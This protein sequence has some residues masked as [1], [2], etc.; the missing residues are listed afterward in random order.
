MSKPPS[1][2][3][4]TLRPRDCCGVNNSIL[5]ERVPKKS[6]RIKFLSDTRT[7][8]FYYAVQ[9]D[10]PQ[11]CRWRGSL[12]ESL[13]RSTKAPLLRRMLI[14]SRFTRFLIISNLPPTLPIRRSFFMSFSILQR[15][16]RW[17][18]VQLK[19]EIFLGDRTKS[20]S[21]TITFKNDTPPTTFDKKKRQKNPGDCLL[22]S[23]RLEETSCCCW[24]AFS[25]VISHYAS[26]VTIVNQLCK[27]LVQQGREQ[28]V[29]NVAERH[30]NLNILAPSGCWALSGDA[31]W[32]RDI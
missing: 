27:R 3:G 24:G 18:E 11:H 28:V 14:A 15:P 12:Y 1:C 32:L 7:P 25:C 20:I 13:A 19:Y 26:A 5:L 21:H 2:T 8:G 4:S 9:A 17:R 23:Q 22:D 16:Y 10:Y 6:E 31:N 29:P 30:L